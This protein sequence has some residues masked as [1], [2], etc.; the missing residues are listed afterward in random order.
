MRYVLMSPEGRK[1][2]V[3]GGRVCVTSSPE[4]CF[5]IPEDVARDLVHAAWHLGWRVRREGGTPEVPDL[6]ELV[7]VLG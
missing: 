3:E 6:R 7:E 1:I 2:T 5:E 4:V